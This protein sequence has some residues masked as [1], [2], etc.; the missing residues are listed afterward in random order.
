MREA[1]VK[2]LGMLYAMASHKDQHLILAADHIGREQLH[3]LVCSAVV[4]KNSLWTLLFTSLNWML[5]DH[6]CSANNAPLQ[7]LITDLMQ[8]WYHSLD[9][10]LFDAYLCLPSLH[11]WQP[12]ATKLT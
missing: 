8:Q 10:H 11:T 7:P 1:V 12:I 5:N 3:L 9:S 2:A 4:S 6:T